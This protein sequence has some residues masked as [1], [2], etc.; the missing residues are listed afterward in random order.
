M[1]SS[2]P[3]NDTGWK[4]HGDLVDVIEAEPDDVTDLIVVDPVDDRHDQSDVH[5][6]LVEVLDGAE[7]DVVEVADLA[8]L[9]VLVAHSVELEIGESQARFGG[10]LRE[11]L[12][13]GEADAVRGALDREIAELRAYRIAGRKCGE[14]VGS[15]P[16]NCTES[17]RR[18]LIEAASSR[19]FWTSSH[20]SSWT[21][22][23]W[24][25]SMKQGSHIM[26]QRLVRSIVS[27][28]PR[29]YLIDDVPCSCRPS[30]GITKSRPG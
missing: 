3:V 10:L 12:V 5:A 24:F 17:C 21:Y 15:P 1:S 9:V 18:G 4:R 13:L 23:T 28:A 22:P 20:S 7:L 29:P 26:L 6:V 19:S 27:T 14:S 11:A 2:R 8:V 30:F 25:A 16:E